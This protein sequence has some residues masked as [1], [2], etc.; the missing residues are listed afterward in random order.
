MEER[1][2]DIEYNDNEREDVDD[3][4]DWDDDDYCYEC[5]GYGDDYSENPETGELEC[6]CFECP[7]NPMR[8]DDWDD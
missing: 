6:N 3:G 2:D 7:F 4:L 1:N 8:T 5:T